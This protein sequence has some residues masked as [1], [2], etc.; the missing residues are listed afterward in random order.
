MSS[1]KTNIYAILDTATH[2]FGPTFEAQ[3]DVVASRMVAHSVLNDP[4]SVLL[5]SPS[6]FVLH[7]LAEFDQVKGVFTPMSDT[8]VNGIPEILGD[9]S[10]NR[11]SIVQGEI[12]FDAERQAS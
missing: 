9:Y 1:I 7:E 2:T 10:R 8:F 6:H 11:P 3:N 4:N 12:P 5:T